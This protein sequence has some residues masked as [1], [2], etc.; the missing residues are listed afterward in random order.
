MRNKASVI[1]RRPIKR[2]VRRDY[3]ELILGCD[4][5]RRMFRPLFLLSRIVNWFLW[6]RSQPLF[7]PLA[8]LFCIL[9]SSAIK[10]FGSTPCLGPF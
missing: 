8:F 3:G 2:D 1:T 10:S 5:C 7:I 4:T 6:L 9:C